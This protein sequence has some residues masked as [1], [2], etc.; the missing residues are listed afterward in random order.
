MKQLSLPF[1]A[2]MM[3]GL[4]LAAFFSPSDTDCSVYKNIPIQFLAEVKKQLRGTAEEGHRWQYRPR[5]PR[6]HSR[7][8]TL[9]QDANRFSVYMVTDYR[10]KLSAWAA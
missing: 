2:E 6:P 4:K 7:Y 1:V 5:G 9:M 3:Q 8:N 10:K